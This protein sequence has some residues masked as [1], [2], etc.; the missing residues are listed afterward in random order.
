[1]FV[2][3][4]ALSLA[5]RRTDRATPLVWYVAAANLID[6]IWP[7]LLLAGVE[8]VRIEPGNTAFT[9]LAFEHYPWTHSLLMVVVWAIAFG[10]FA[11]WR[12]V[13][14]G[15]AKLIAALVLS[16]WVLDA[17]THAP[18]LPLWPG[19]TTMIGF[20]LWNSIPASFAVES[21]LWISGLALFL[22]AR[23]PRGI[24]G[25]VALWSFVAVCTLMWAASPYSPPPP[26]ERSLAY[27]GLFGW[28]IIPWAIWIERTSEQ[29]AG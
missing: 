8:R 19:S 11:R 22:G 13:A 12:G 27:F 29:R 6:L 17:I 15:Q 24:Q 23:R 28:I 18:D 5:A 1:M 25:N 21:A 14:T 9:P 26:D 20:G 7:L 10:A 3:H 2:G 16:H 4:L